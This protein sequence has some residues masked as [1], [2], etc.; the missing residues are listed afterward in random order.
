MEMN[1][2]VHG[3]LLFFPTMAVSVS[4]SSPL[5]KYSSSSSSD[6]GSAMIAIPVLQCSDDTQH[7]PVQHWV[8][9]THLDVVDSQRV[10]G[11]LL[12]S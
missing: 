1:L 2:A 12:S 3:S 7:P 6:E 9:I 11:P 5:M 10:Y 8:R 4:D